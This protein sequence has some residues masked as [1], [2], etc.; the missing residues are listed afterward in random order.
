MSALSPLSFCPYPASLS[1][2]ETIEVAAEHERAWVFGDGS[3]DT[4]NLLDML[5]RWG[6]VASV[7]NDQFNL[8]E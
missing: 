3:V 6:Y 5:A 7:L 1:W 4:E 2:V 8:L